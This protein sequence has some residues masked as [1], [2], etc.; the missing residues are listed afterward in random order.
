[1]GGGQ[2]QR[3]RVDVPALARLLGDTAAAQRGYAGHEAVV[4]AALLSAGLVLG[5]RALLVL[6]R[7]LALGRRVAALLAVAL[8]RGRAVLLVVVVAALGRAVALDAKDEGQRDVAAAGIR[9]AMATTMTAPT[10]MTGA[11]GLQLEAAGD[12]GSHPAGAA[13]RCSNPG[14]TCRRWRDESLEDWRGLRR[15]REAGEQAGQRAGVWSMVEGT[16]GTLA[17]LTFARR[18]SKEGK[19]FLFETWTADEVGTYS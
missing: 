9:S 1:M 12:G 16:K 4:A 13:A 11:V 15:G 18:R 5:G 2:R 10:T 3:Q 19:G 7:G 14:W 6:H 8:G 17:G